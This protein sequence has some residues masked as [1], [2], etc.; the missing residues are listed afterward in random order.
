MQCW[1]R[2]CATKTGEI[3]NSNPRLSS[4]FKYSNVSLLQKPFGSK[5]QPG[6]EM[7]DWSTKTI[8]KTAYFFLSIQGKLCTIQTESAK[9]MLLSGRKPAKTHKKS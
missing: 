5:K 6:S 8:P 1:R 9:V 3:K 2:G 7:K 4:S